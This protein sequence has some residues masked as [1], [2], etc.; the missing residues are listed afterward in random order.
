MCQTLDIDQARLLAK[1]V[2]DGADLIEAGLAEYLVA[3]NTD[4]DNRVV[5]EERLYPIVG[6]LSAACPTRAASAG[7]YRC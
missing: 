1:R 7:R 5:A 6:F 4:D 2:A 3:L